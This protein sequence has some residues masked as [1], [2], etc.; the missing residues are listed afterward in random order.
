MGQIE[1][2]LISDL[3]SAGFNFRDIN[4]LYK[5]N[6]FLPIAAIDI[7][8]KWLPNIYE[9]HIGSGECLVRSLICPSD[10]YNPKVLIELFEKSNL[11]ETLKCTIGFVLSITNTSEIKDWLL[12]QLLDKEHS[13]GRAGL[14]DGIVPK[15]GFN[16]KDELK[17]FFLKYLISIRTTRPFKN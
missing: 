9:E 3:K 1:R 11:N 16:T 12:S 8:L 17:K 2:K 7:I 6:D 13:F 5:Q 10:Q 14:L 4:H 15:G